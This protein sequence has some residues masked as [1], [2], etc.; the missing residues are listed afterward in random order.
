[1]YLLIIISFFLYIETLRKYPVLTSLAREVLE[2]Y[3]FKGTNVTIPKGTKVWLPIFA[4]QRDPDIY[5]DPEKF[6]PERFSDEAVAA[7]HPMSYL[8]FGD[9]PRNCIGKLENNPNLL[10]IINLKI[11]KALR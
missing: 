4:I 10:T 7:R 6:D 2:N 8:P 1:M 11:I 9:G 5:P 3:T